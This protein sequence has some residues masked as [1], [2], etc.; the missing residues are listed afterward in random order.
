[1]ISKR[2]A[3]MS[4]ATLCSA[5]AIGLV[6]QHTSRSPQASVAASVVEPTVALPDLPADA[7][8]QI[9]AISLTAATPEEVDGN[10]Q[11]V[12]RQDPE[13][14]CEMTAEAVPGPMAEVRLT[15]LSLCRPGERLTIHH[16]GMMFSS[17]LDATGALTVQIPALSSSAV[18]IVEPKSGR[19]AVATTSVPDLDLVSRVVL[20]WAGNSGF[21]LHAREFG[22]GYGSAGHVWRG[23]DLTAG[24]GSVVQLGDAT[25][26]APRLAEVYSVPR[27]GGD[28]SGAI[29][30]TV[31]AEVTAIN[32]GRDVSAQTLELRDGRLRTRDLTL[33]MPDC[34]ATG[35]FL[36]LNNLLE[37]LKIAAN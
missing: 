23:A 16:N 5:L 8:L 27:L 14:S 13:T 2:T 29:D 10:A 25:Q 15:V 35:D 28:Q 37:T 19:G 7:P 26:L 3:L 34:A 18:F 9:E 33:A 20:Q 30:L 11:K 21:E 17:R 32:C 36:V 22:A 1:M 12:L 6:M 4:A 31:E 24:R